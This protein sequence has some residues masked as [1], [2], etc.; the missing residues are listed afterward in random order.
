MNPEKKCAMK[1]N[2]TGYSLL[3]DTLDTPHAS[4]AQA[5]AQMAT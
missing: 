2:L 4:E 3:Y 5:W 1:G